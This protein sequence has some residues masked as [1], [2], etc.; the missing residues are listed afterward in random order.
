MQTP[1]CH[2]AALAPRSAAPS[3]V[4]THVMLVLASVSDTVPVCNAAP[5]VPKERAGR[6]SLLYT[7]MQKQL[8]A[9]FTPPALLQMVCELQCTLGEPL[10]QFTV[11]CRSLRTSPSLLPNQCP[12][13]IFTIQ[14]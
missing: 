9:D 7:V 8:D 14:L 13:S 6:L 5:S 12:S 4:D 10:A 11:D 3:C 2:R 1:I